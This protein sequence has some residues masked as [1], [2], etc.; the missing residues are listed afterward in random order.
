MLDDAMARGWCWWLVGVAVAGCGSEAPAGRSAAG[1]GVRPGA[2]DRARAPGEGAPSPGTVAEA[3]R[4]PAPPTPLAER[5]GGHLA[6]ICTKA[7]SD[8]MR[9]DGALDRSLSGTWKGEYAGG[10]G[11][12]PTRFEA[13]L[14]VI[15]G[16][17]DGTTTE[18]N[19]FGPSYHA[20][21]EASLTGDAFATRQ[22]VVLKTYR[23]GTVTHSVLYVGRL[24]EAGTRIDG[25]WRVGGAQGTFWMERAAGPANAWP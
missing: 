13:T 22:V 25:H 4:C 12:T 8:T 11:S 24:D 9:V 2:E 1:D 10:L 21:L 20:E 17:V 7:A 3:A 5:M 16:V 18:P 15:G 23:T 6:E 19:T 14:T